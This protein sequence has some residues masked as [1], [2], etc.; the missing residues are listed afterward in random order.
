MLIDQYHR[1][2]S[3]LRLSVTDRC[4]LKCFYCRPAGIFSARRHS[5]M[6]TFE[7]LYRLVQIAV[8]L[9]VKKVR[10]TGGEP[11]VRKGVVDFIP[12]LSGIVGL[13]DL[14][15][16]TNGVFLK[17]CLEKIY[18]GGIHRLNIS[19]DT[20]QR[21]RYRKITGA[22][23]FDTVWETIHRASAMGFDPI[24]INVVAINGVMTICT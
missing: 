11:L 14:S 4:N 19:L 24:K 16:T 10:L 17:N 2:I 21:E 22:D 13:E 23:L 7:E 15:L 5:D 1:N 9:G 18:A 3:Y 12:Q 8:S 6:L 20:L